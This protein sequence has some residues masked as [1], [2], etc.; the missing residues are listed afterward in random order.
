MPLPYFCFVYSFFVFH[1]W[2]N[3]NEKKHLHWCR[4]VA[5]ARDVDDNLPP[6]TLQTSCNINSAEWPVLTFTAY[7]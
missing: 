4:D 7:I 2:S 3:A 6:L 1:P 5:C